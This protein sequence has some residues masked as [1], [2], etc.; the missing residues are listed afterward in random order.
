MAII[1][2]ALAL[3]ISLRTR[4]GEHRSSAA[5]AGAIRA[6]NGGCR[7]CVSPTCEIGNCRYVSILKMTL[8]QKITSRRG[9]HCSSAAA[10][11]AIRVENGGCRYCVSPTREIVCNLFC[12]RA[13]STSLRISTGGR[14]MAAPT[15]GGLEL[16][17]HLENGNISKTSAKNNR[18][19]AKETTAILNANC[20][21]G[22]QFWVCFRLGIYSVIGKGGYPPEQNPTKTNQGNCP[23]WHPGREPKEAD[24]ISREML[25]F[26]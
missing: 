11:G 4:R 17:C 20:P 10:T 23:P 15:G 24:Q 6:E 22:E 14:P 1:V 3:L 21:C 2:Y 8:P 12:T 18:D 7:N 26:E 13:F 19:S 25:R 16:L 5:A 9:E